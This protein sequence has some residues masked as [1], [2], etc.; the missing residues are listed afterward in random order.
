MD[1]DTPQRRVDRIGIFETQNSEAVLAMAIKKV[2]YNDDDK[3]N[4]DR[5]TY[6]DKAVNHMVSCM[7]LFPDYGGYEQMLGRFN[8]GGGGMVR[9][10]VNE[11][12]IKKVHMPI[13][14]K[15]RTRKAQKQRRRLQDSHNVG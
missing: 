15:S 14:G 3:P 5:K 8:Q 6:S 13:D 12:Q 1:V 7:T 10:W 2:L 4:L 9:D 11:K